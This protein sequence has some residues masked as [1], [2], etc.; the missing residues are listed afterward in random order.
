[1]FASIAC[2]A[3]LLLAPAGAEASPP[4]FIGIELIA[5]DTL[6]DPGR[7]METTILVVAGKKLK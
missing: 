7:R 1:M 2:A 6:V 4:A 5:R 3:M